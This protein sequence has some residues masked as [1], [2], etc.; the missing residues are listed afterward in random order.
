[1]QLLCPL[2][3]LQFQAVEK[4]PPQIG[5]HN[6]DVCHLSQEVDGNVTPLACRCLSASHLFLCSLSSG[7][8][9]IT[10]LCQAAHP[11]QQTQKMDCFLLNPLF[12]NKKYYPPQPLGTHSFLFHCPKYGYVP[13]PK[14][15]IRKRFTKRSK[16]RQLLLSYTGRGRYPNK[17]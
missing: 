2:R 17:I 11:G 16:Y 6:M 3:Q 7:W 8:Q 10:K 15:I 5:K 4:S 14:P 1:M 9:Q 12:N 13:T